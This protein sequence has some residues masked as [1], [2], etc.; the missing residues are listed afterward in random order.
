M[1]DVKISYTCSY[2]NAN[3]HANNLKV[4]LFPYKDLKF[5]YS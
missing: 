1:K 2:L 5:R 3:L 4:N